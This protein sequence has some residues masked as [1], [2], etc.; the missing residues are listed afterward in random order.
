MSLQHFAS[1]YG[2]QSLFHYFAG[3]DDLIKVIRDKYL[4]AK[5]LDKLD[6]TIDKLPLNALCPDNKM[7]SAL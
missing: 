7:R 2:G 3:E 6:P 4:M 1:F 5:N